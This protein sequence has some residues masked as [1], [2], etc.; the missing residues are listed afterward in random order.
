[1]S[2]D[3]PILLPRLNATVASFFVNRTPSEH[4]PLVKPS[5]LPR[6]DVHVVTLAAA[7]LPS[8]LTYIVVV[9]V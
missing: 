8:P 1:M 5:I 3:Q 9:A 6:S 4:S 2:E 7:V